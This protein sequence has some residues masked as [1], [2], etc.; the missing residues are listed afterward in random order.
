MKQVLVV[1]GAGGVGAALVTELLD[2]GRAVVVAGRR[3]AADARVRHTRLLDATTAD[4]RA[5]YDELE[6][7]SAAPIDGVVFVA[8][9]AVFG[10]TARIPAQR[11]RAMFELN[12]WACTA[13][14]MAAGEHWTERGRPGTFLAVLSVVA[15]RAVPFEAYYA[16]SKAAAARMLECL[17]LEYGA[18]QIRFAGA[19][20]G[21]L[22]TSFRSRAEWYGVERA[23]ESRGTSAAQTARALIALLDG[24]RSARVIGWRERTIDLADRFTPGLYDRAVL[25]RR[26]KRS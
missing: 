20:P 6:A 13:A 16:A 3:N 17:Q 9:D 10:R 5:V 15:R 21:T 12:F 7:A 24:R 2:R 11:A 8:G 23:P 25:R 19:C 4:W 1:G 18:R 14:A 26:A 22:D